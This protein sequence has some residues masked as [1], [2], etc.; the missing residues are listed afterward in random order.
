MVDLIAYFG[1]FLLIVSSQFRIRRTNQLIRILGLTVWVV[2]GIAIDNTPIIVV[3][4][5]SI[6]A[7]FLAMWRF[8]SGK[9]KIKYNGV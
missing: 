4:V 8:S 5:I 3:D 6:L 9:Y 2:Y 7:E 1:T